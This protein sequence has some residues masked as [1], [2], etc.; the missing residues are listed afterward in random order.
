MSNQKWENLQF[1]QDFKTGNSIPLNTELCNV[2]CYCSNTKNFLLYSNFSL[3]PFHLHH[4][5]QKEK[6]WNILIKFLN[7]MLM[8]SFSTAR[9]L[10]CA[11]VIAICD[12][13]RFCYIPST[14]TFNS[15]ILIYMKSTLFSRFRSL[16]AHFNAILPSLTS[17]SGECWMFMR[18][19]REKKL[20]C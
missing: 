7:E 14:S 3:H 16:N 4:R 11:Y 5:E 12:F 9:K 17:S 6:N 1:E 18:Y 20:F 10:F 13:T 2:N 15:L 19:S 8:K